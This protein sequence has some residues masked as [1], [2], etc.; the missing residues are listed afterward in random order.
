MS[1]ALLGRPRLV[2]D[3]LMII[4]I[5]ITIITWLITAATSSV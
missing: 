2:I 5:I 4:M 1:P 3:N